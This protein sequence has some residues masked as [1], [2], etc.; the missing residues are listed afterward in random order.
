MA[1]RN[2]KTAPPPPCQPGDDVQVLRRRM[3]PRAGMILDVQFHAG[4]A[5]DMP[6]WGPWGWGYQIT[7]L[8][9]GVVE[10]FTF[11]CRRSSRSWDPMI[12]VTRAGSETLAMR[13]KSA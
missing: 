12:R 13:G 4:D 10:P 5:P 1:G 8:P 6:G 2:P 11:L 9:D 7:W 3:P